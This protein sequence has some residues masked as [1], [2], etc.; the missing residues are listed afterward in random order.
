MG[1][2][3][4]QIGL[5]L[6]RPPLW[7]LAIALVV[8]VALIGPQIIVPQTTEFTYILEALSLAV[9]YFAWRTKG[10]PAALILVLPLAFLVGWDGIF[11]SWL[12]IA[13]LGMHAVLSFLLFTVIL[14]LW[15][16]ALGKRLPIGRFVL[17]TIA[18]SAA[19]LAAAWINGQL[20][21]TKSLDTGLAQ[22]EHMG[23]NLL[24]GASFALGLEIGEFRRRAELRS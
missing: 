24:L 6:I 15:W 10:C 19:G 8:G 16:Q 17:M 5:E 14:S 3:D 12:R 9:L 21:E 18:F 4:N 22:L 13:T 11:S 23:R 20:V 7:G 1:N 2:S